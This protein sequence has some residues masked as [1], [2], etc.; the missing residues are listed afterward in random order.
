MHAPG[1]EIW[2]TGFG[3]YRF[4]RHQAVRAWNSNSRPSLP[5]V[6]EKLSSLFKDK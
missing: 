6:V 3:D 2:I 5:D 1:K 4:S